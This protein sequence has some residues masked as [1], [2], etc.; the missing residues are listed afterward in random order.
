[1]SAGKFEFFFNSDSN[2]LIAYT[3]DTTG[4]FM[5]P[6][7]GTVPAGIEGIK[8]GGTN[9]FKFA[10]DQSLAN[11]PWLYILGK[12][13]SA[14]VP[15][16]GNEVSDVTVFPNP[17]QNEAHIKLALTKSGTIRISLYDDLGREAVSIANGE[18]YQGSYD[19]PLDLRE[20]PAGHYTLRVESGGKA[21]STSVNVVR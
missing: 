4:N 2:R 15:L 7:S 5:F 11:T 16:A 8:I 10:I 14:S 6:S 13:T 18:L 19:L 17:A 9:T 21:M 20:L 3:L 1:M 12:N